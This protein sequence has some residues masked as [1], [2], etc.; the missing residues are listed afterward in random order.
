MP[1]SCSRW[2]SGSAPCRDTNTAPSTCPPRANRSNRSR[3]AGSPSTANTSC[4]SCAATAACTPRS[5]WEKYG[6]AKN[7][8]SDSATTNAIESLRRVISERAARLVT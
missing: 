4:T 6:S 5:T 2:G 7:R 1:A 3:S 8:S